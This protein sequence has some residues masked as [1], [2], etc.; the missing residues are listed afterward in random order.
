M[1]TVTDFIFLGSK[2]TA[3]GDY[4]HESKR[5]LPLESKIDDKPWQHIKKQRHYSANKGPSSQRY[6]FSSSHIWMWELDYKESWV[7]KNWC[8]W[9]VVLEKS[10][11]SPLDCKEIIL[12]NPKGNQTWIF[13]GRIDIEAETPILWP[14][15][16]SVDSLGKILMLEKNEGGRRRG[17]QRMIWLD[18]VID[19]LDMNLSKFQELVMDREAW[20][21]AVHGVTKSRT[22]LSSLTDLGAQ[23]LG[24]LLGPQKL[25]RH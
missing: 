14:L 23:P 11:E 15:M 9:T 8:F 19:S 17:Q 18:G 20:H 5:H 1:E 12:S 10:R 3:N 21:A 4:S 6:V 24:K 13:I 7:P 16:R 2:V 25:L 22:R